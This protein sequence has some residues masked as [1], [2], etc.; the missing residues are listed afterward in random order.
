MPR[1]KIKHLTASDGLKRWENQ[2]SACKLGALCSATH[3]PS[4]LGKAL[5][6]PELNLIS[7]GRRGLD[8]MLC[9]VPPSPGPLYS[10]TPPSISLQ[11]II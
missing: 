8:Q 4:D 10:R 2:E 7:C 3:L 5:T 11:E 1:I 6:L 9:M